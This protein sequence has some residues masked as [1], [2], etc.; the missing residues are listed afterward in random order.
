MTGDYGTFE[1]AYTKK[2]D[3]A[4]ISTRLRVQD[5]E[6]VPKGVSAYEALDAGRRDGISF[7]IFYNDLPIAL[8]G[9]VESH[10]FSNIWM[11]GT[12]CVSK[13]RRELLTHGKKFAMK[14]IGNFPYGANY[15]WTGNHQSMRWLKFIGA[16][17]GE[18]V[19][20]DSK[21]FL[22]FKIYK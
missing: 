16:E 13:I 10:G 22:P 6:E 17:F 2:I 3:V 21:E 15:V 1:V 14:L 20:I 11:V 8:F 7:T 12:N 5:M 9:S 19:I 18:P 4:Y